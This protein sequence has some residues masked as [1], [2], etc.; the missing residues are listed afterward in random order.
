[1]TCVGHWL[2]WT[3]DGLTMVYV[4]L[5]QVWPWTSLSICWPGHSPGLA[6]GWAGHGMVWTWAEL[7]MGWYVHELGWAWDGLVMD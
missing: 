6:M 2:C 4:G 1:M 5:V 3:F 7:V